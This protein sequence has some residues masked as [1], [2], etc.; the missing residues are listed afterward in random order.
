M[1]YCTLSTL[2]RNGGCHL[3]DTGI[4]S[5]V[6]TS[7]CEDFQS[8]FPGQNST[9]GCHIACTMSLPPMLYQPL[10]YMTFWG[11]RCYTGSLE[12]WGELLS[13]GSGVEGRYFLIALWDIYLHPT[14]V[15]R[16]SPLN[17]V[18]TSLWVLNKKDI[19]PCCLDY[20]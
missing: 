16:R 20:T 18:C 15:G 9:E 12:F 19:I 6:Y 14:P 10:S 13:H 1:P 5:T 8:K 3:Q 11:N 17:T 2:V 7:L 4:L